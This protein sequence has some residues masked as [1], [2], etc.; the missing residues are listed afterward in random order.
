MSTNGIWFSTR[1]VC[2]L[3][4]LTFKI[5]WFYIST[6]ESR[7]SITDHIHSFIHSFLMVFMKC[8]YVRV[9]PHSW[10]FCWQPKI[11]HTANKSTS[12]AAA[13]P[14][15]EP[16]DAS[17]QRRMAVRISYC[18]VSAQLGA[19]HGRTPGYGL[20][21]RCWFRFGIPDS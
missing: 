5:V 4:F 16:A 2:R 8:W 7:V 9:K 18:G 12:T 20:R 1:A 6:L 11:S 3:S 10:R 15:A 14:P 17:F 21:L 13:S 19:W